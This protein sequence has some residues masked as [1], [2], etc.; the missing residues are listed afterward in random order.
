RGH[1]VSVGVKR[2]LSGESREPMPVAVAKANRL[3]P[4]EFMLS[5]GTLFASSQAIGRNYFKQL[6]EVIWLF[7]VLKNIRRDTDPFLRTA[8]P[9]VDIRANFTCCFQSAWHQFRKARSICTKPVND[10]SACGTT[11]ARIP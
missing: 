9:D 6:F 8:N 7:V 2:Q 10:V 3:A 5:S 11:E 4:A 1:S